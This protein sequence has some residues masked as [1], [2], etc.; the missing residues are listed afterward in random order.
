M[1]TAIGSAVWQKLKHGS[2]DWIA[3]TALFLLTF[4]VFF[5]LIKWF[6]SAPPPANAEQEP[7]PKP[8]SDPETQ[9]G[10]SVDGLFTPLQIEAFSI[11]KDLRDFLASLDP[12]PADPVRNPGE[13]NND[14]MARLITVRSDRQGKWRLKLMNGYANRKFGQRITALMHRAGEEVEYPAYVP[15]YAETPPMNQDD[16]RK[17]AQQMEMVAIWI[18][19]KERNEVNLL[20]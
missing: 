14:Y 18:N 1:V 13:S 7:S 17:L 15:N 11:A 19:R 5:V 10:H 9:L 20:K 6:K 2:V 4:A 16:I 8:A 3:I 12:F